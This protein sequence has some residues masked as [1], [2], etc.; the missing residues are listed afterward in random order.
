MT[1]LGALL[2]AEVCADAALAR[3]G[4]PFSKSR[5]VGLC[6]LL[7]LFSDFANLRRVPEGVRGCDDCKFV[8][9]DRSEKGMRNLHGAQIGGGFDE[10]DNAGASGQA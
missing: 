1:M 8:T 9:G 4:A 6:M 7:D 2:D 10:L 5:R 3:I